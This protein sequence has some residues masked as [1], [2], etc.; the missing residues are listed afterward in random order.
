MAGPFPFS[1]SFTGSLFWLSA[2]ELRISYNGA[3]SRNGNS[4]PCRSWATAP[5]YYRSVRLRFTSDGECLLQRYDPVVD[6]SH[7][8]RAGELQLP[9]VFV[10]N[11]DG[12]CGIPVDVRDYHSQRF[13]EILETSH[14]PRSS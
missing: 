14:P 7:E 4:A 10:G 6:G 12:A 13:A 9:D 5:D 8:N 2:V 3:A 11:H 1:L